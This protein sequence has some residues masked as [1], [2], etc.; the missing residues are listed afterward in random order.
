MKVGGLPYRDSASPWPTDN[1]GIP[2]TF[3]AQI[4]FADSRD[5]IPEV[6]GD[7]LLVFSDDDIKLYFEWVSIDEN[8]LL[9]QYDE[10]PEQME[11]VKPY[12]GT[13]HRTFDI[14]D[15][16]K[17]DDLL[18]NNTDGTKIG[19]IPNWCQE[20]YTKLNG[21]FLC[22]LQSVLPV[23]GSQYPLMNRET[24]EDEYESLLFGG[25]AIMYAFFDG[26]NIDY[27]LLAE[28]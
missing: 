3:Q 26:T 1:A 6:P 2:L 16:S 25:L 22:Q 10:I 5:I 24:C 18:I 4:V 17:N 7:I 27:V 12:F 11:R 15:T 20:V 23:S 9:V 28:D 13:R 14:I 21:N 8:M 19:G